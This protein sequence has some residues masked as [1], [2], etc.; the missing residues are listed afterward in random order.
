MKRMKLVILL[1]AAMT[2]FLFCRQFCRQSS[3]EGI[4]RA[5]TARMLAWTVCGMN[6][7][8]SKS[9]EPLIDVD[10]SLWYADEITAVLTDGLMKKDG[11]LFR[12]TDILTW[13]EASDI[14]ARLG[15]SISIPITCKNRPIP[16][17]KWLHYFD[18]WLSHHKMAITRTLTI[19]A[20]PSADSTLDRWQVKTDCGVYS[21]QG[22]ILESYLGQSVTA[23]I[24][25]DQ[26]LMICPRNNTHP[27]IMNVTKAESRTR[28]ETNETQSEPEAHNETL[29]CP[30]IPSD[31]RVCLMNDD[32]TSERHTTIIL[33]CEAPWQ[34]IFKDQTIQHAAGE[35]AELTARDFSENGDTA[36]IT[37]ESGQPVCAASL[38]RS[39][40]H[41]VYTGRLRIIRNGDSLYLVNILP[42][43]EYLKGV[44]PSEMPASYAP[45][46]LKS[47]AVCARSYAMT[48]LRNPKYSFA[49]LNDSTSCQVYMNQGTDPRTDN[50]VE[51]T[52]GEVLSFHQQIA[53]AKYFSSS[54]GSLSS[55]DD[56]WTYPDTGQGDSYMTARLET[57]PPI[58]CALS[59]EEAFREFI[60]RP[61]EDTYLE[62][63]D[64]WFRWQ[65]TL[66]IESIRSNISESFTKRM[67]ADP[68]RFTLLSSDGTINADDI[69]QVKA[70]KRAASGVLQQIKL[71]GKDQELT[72]SGEYNIRCLLAP[73]ADEIITLQDGSIRNGMSLL[74]SGYFFLEAIRDNGEITGYKIY[75]GGFGHGAG[76]SQNGANELAEKGYDYKK[77]LKYFFEGI[78]I[79]NV[80]PLNSHES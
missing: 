63:S 72:V 48:A 75:G 13:Q 67:A 35:M 71:T 45:E 68:K 49:D 53:S 29:Q 20:L 77:I 59:S 42:V 38:N 14:A 32:F 9:G 39:F 4:T 79:K 74:P 18:L 1:L 3:A 5:Q 41:P 62:A 30:D 51:A 43:E 47:Q 52:A 17:E 16:L 66:S 40:G 23:Y 46:A 58:A 21:S 64:P 15:I 33:T 27:E 10:S 28:Q 61:K 44:V 34:M 55:D 56:I 31:I 57:E 8:S 36:E 6:K 69:L 76:L 37:T 80:S 7:N 50:A 60:L 19:E 54:C 73:S 70:A 11:D 26:M 24:V 78:D 22:L 65:I 12:P 2:L 25:G